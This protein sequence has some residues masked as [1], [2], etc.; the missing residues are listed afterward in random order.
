MSRNAANPTQA[1]AELYR[2]SF[3][4]TRLP[5]GEGQELVYSP[6]TRSARALPP[7]SVRLLQGC[8]A[9]ATLDEHTAHLCRELNLPPQQGPQVRQELAALAQSGLLLSQRDL[10]TP[11][12]GQIG[13]SP[14][15]I[16]V[17]GIPTRNRTPSLRRCL[18]SYI[19]NNHRH[20]RSVQYLVVDDSS[21]PGVQDANRQLLLELKARHSVALAYAGPEE[22]TRFAE[23]LVQRTGLPAEDVHFGVVNDDRFPIT[24]GAGRNAILLHAVGEALLQ[25]DDDT[26]CRLAP[27]PGTQGGLAFTSEYDPTEFWFPAQGEPFPAVVGDEPSILAI[28]EQMLGKGLGNCLAEMPNGLGVDLDRAGAGFFRRAASTGGRV[29]ATA[30]G[31]M[32]DSGM[33]S[34]LYFLSLEGPAR[35]R[36]L[37]SEGVYRQAF[38]RQQVVRGVRQP[39]ISDGTLCMALNLGLDHRELLPP[40]TPVQRNQ[41]GVFGALLRACVTGGCFGFLPWTLL[42]RSPVPRHLLPEDLWKSAA[43]VTSGQ[44]LQALVGSFAPGPNPVDAR[45]S[46]L[47]LG[48]ALEDWGAARPTDFEELA[49]LALWNQ[50]SRKVVQLENQLRAA[51]GQPAFWAQDVRRLLALW[52]QALPEREYLAPSDLVRAFG[53]DAFACL[54]RLVRR[55]GRLLQV[56]PDMVAA[57]KDLR[58]GGRQL[59]VEV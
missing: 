7:L 14:P 54:Q 46:L 27:V 42:H 37:H 32:G 55:F 4:F 26:V 36:L 1:G 49:R 51:Q 21:D 45:K 53:N 33:G 8:R 31:V 28:H 12:R 9:F 59:A 38:A 47:A 22:K 58:A 2:G 19:N 30:A 44:I 13:P 11:L 23:A 34:P 24:T 17:L 35:A 40:F 56:W 57:A 48:R 39:T 16:T 3:E 29:L 25:V 6:L 18:E 15:R 5:L 10:L 52:R 20:G 50:T 41:D 43:Q